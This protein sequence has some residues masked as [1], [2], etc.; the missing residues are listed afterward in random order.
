[1]EALE[2]FLETEPEN[3]VPLLPEDK[4]DMANALLT[5]AKLAVLGGKLVD[6]LSPEA[7]EQMVNAVREL[8][9]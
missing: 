5:G 6:Q 1:M 9:N 3:L 8:C 2:A 7:K 4:Q